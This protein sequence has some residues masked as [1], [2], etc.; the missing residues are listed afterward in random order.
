[1]KCRESSGFPAT[2][3]GDKRGMAHNHAC[4]ENSSQIC[5]SSRRCMQKTI[6][7]PVQHTG[8][9]T[10]L[11]VF[12]EHLIFNHCCQIRW[13]EHSARDTR[14]FREPAFIFCQ[15]ETGGH[16]VI[17]MLKGTGPNNA[18]ARVEMN[19]ADVHITSL[20]LTVLNHR[21]SLN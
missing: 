21:M 10:Q 20:Q 3:R 2:R 6:Q 5:K 14:T 15:S 13:H 8:G 16:F 1:M 17:T 9:C 19:S 11:S 4:T 7:H 18:W 12:S